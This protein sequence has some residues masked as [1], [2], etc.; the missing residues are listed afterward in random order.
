MV[1]NLQRVRIHQTQNGTLKVNLVQVMKKKELKQHQMKQRFVV[2]FQ[3]VVKT[4]NM[5]VILIGYFPHNQMILA[6][7]FYSLCFGV[8]I[9][10]TWHHL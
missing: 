4:C 3:V 8:S 5:V 9:R 10:P 1:M 6:V 2:C 7:L